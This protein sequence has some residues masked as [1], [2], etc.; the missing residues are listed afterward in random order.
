M[1]TCCTSLNP[2]NY[3]P[4]GRGMLE[5]FDNDME[6][7]NLRAS[8]L[9]NFIHVMS[10]NLLADQLATTEFHPHQSADILKFSF[11]STRLIE[12]IS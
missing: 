10:Y 2:E 11:R 12:E 9:K 1:G 5:P 6:E 3:P 7:K 4:V 8:L